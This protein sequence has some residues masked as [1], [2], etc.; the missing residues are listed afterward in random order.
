MAKKRKPIVRCAVCGAKATHHVLS[1]PM[2]DSIPCEVFRQETIREELKAAED[3]GK[4]V[5]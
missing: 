3:S 1:V 5:Q 2:C 4:E